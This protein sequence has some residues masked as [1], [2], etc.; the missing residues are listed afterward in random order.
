MFHVS[1]LLQL[2]LGCLQALSRH[3]CLDIVSRLRGLTL[4]EAGRTQ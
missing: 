1:Y 2:G 3:E 4:C